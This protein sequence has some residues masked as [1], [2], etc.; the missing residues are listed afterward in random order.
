MQLGEKLQV[1][2]QSYNDIVSQHSCDI[3]LTHLVESSGKVSCASIKHLHL[4]YLTDQTLT[5][6]PDIVV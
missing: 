5:Q 2:K 3:G 1:L 4:L 6:L